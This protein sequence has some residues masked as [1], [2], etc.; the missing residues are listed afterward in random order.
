MT[1][2][3]RNG[4]I[5]LILAIVF[6][7]PGLAAYAFYQH[8]QWL[9]NTNNRGQLLSPPLLLNKNEL[10]PKWSLILWYP[11]A[12]NALCQKEIDKL[13]RIRL[14]LGRR[15]YLVDILLVLP[16][17]HATISTNNQHAFKEQDIHILALSGEN[18]R[19]DA[20]TDKP[21]FFI[22]SPSNYLILRYNIDANAHDIFHDIQQLAHSSE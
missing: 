4:L 14:A 21:E 17:E 10:S 9:A 15:L 7:C 11:K 8:P 19:I 18:R 3:K 12:C 1:A 5:L 16:D 13:A 2:Q 22:A 20:F 6:I